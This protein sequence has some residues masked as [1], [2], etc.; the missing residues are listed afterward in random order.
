MRITSIV[1]IVVSC[2]TAFADEPVKVTHPLSAEVRAAM[3]DRQEAVLRQNS[4]EDG[5]KLTVGQHS[6]RG[7]ALFFLGRFKESV[8]EYEAMVKLDP[9]LDASHW[10]LGIAY[11]FARTPKQ[12]AAQ[13]D[14]YHS[15]DDV[16]RENGIWRYLCQ[17]H[18]TDAKTAKKELLKYEKDDREPFPAVYKL[19]DDSLTPEQALEAIPKDLPTTQR[20]MRLFYTELY[21]GMHLVV[22]KQPEKAAQYLALATSRKWPQRAGFG[23]NYMWHVGRVQLEQLLR[24]ADRKK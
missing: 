21:I 2:S 15:F 24:N 17:Y 22:K 11:F 1:L 7:D 13:F 16:D 6:R 9:S 10:R 14:K 4:S 12:G 20:E 19:F 8:Q 5:R 18:A 3:R 23:P